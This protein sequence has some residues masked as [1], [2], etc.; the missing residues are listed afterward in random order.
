MSEQLTFDFV[1]SHPTTR[2]TTVYLL[3]DVGPSPAELRTAFNPQYQ[4]RN[5]FR[6]A[7]V[8]VDGIP[9]V[10][11]WGTIGAGRTPSWSEHLALLVGEQVDLAHHMAAAALVLPVDDNVFAVC[12][13]HGH[14]LL[15]GA[16]VAPSFGLEYVLRAV[17]P[18]RVNELTHTRPDVRVYTD[19]TSTAGDQHVRDF[20]LDVYGEHCSR[21]TGRARGTGL[22]AERDAR[23]WDKR[24]RVT[25]GDSLSLHLAVDAAHLVADLRAIAALRAEKP[26]PGFEAVSYLRSLARHDP[27]T[28]LLNQKLA[29][30]LPD[31]RQIAFT[32][33]VSPVGDVAQSRTVR[34]SLGRGHKPFHTDDVTTETF[35]RFLAELPVELR[36]GALEKA[37][38]QPLSDPDGGDP[39]EPSTS[40]LRWLVAEITLA[41]GHFFRRQ[42]KWY[43]VAPDHLAR[44]D[45]EVRA[46]FAASPHY[47]LPVWPTRAE[48]A[49]R[50]L[51]DAHERGYNGLAAETLGWACLD[52]DL[53]KCDVH[54]GGFEPA[55]L[56]T[57]DGTLVHVKRAEDSGPLSHLFVQGRVSADALHSQVDANQEFVAKATRSF[58][59]FPQGLFKPQRVVFAIALKT[60]ADLTP[61]SLFTMS[62][63]SLLDTARRLKSM[64]IEVHVQGIDNRARAVQ[65]RAEKRARQGR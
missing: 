39:T 20:E 37:R 8:L 49:V 4:E 12:F 36:L 28:G 52:R 56:V 13:G 53:I 27:R 44:I 32:P 23:T 48:A 51:T 7:E 64:G 9:A 24:S 6:T 65:D 45:A 62:K 42:N 63:I 14:L 10:A 60:G 58:P 16:R 34:V 21:L 46:L 43:E 30:E 55:D 57:P 18:H 19:R 17:D 29:E 41:D 40:A 22:S 5:S 3:Q 47:N 35:R 2:P 50:Q 11:L 33:P 38:M 1:D 61:D 15:D 25:G 31:S 59:G 26:D 54:P